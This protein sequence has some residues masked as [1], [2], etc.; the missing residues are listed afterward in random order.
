MFVTVSF[1]PGITY[2]NSLLRRGP[3][4]SQGVW[5][6]GKTSTTRVLF[7]NYV[8]LHWNI[9]RQGK[10]HGT[11]Q[12][13]RQGVSAELEKRRTSTS[14]PG[15]SLLLWER[16]WR[17][18]RQLKRRRS[19][20]FPAVLSYFECDDTCQSCRE[21][22]AWFQ[23]FS[24]HSDGASWVGLNFDQL[25]QD[26]NAFRSSSPFQDHNPQ[27]SYHARAAREGRGKSFLASYLAI[28]S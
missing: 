27:E 16:G 24:A 12:I 20:S 26:V 2:F 9:Q 10:S 3:F 15:F 13:Q 19:V 11:R 1:E 23:A 4:V 21:N 18:L 6:E 17:D 14:F 7:F 5:G 28:V 22:R 25:K 8:Y